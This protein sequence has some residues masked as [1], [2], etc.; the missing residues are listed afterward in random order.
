MSVI[1]VSHVALARARRDLEKAYLA[2]DWDHVRLCDRQLG[3][4]L[5]LAFADEHRN[6]RALVEELERVLGLYA[7]MVTA[8][9]VEAAGRLLPS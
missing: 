9:P 3:H 1:A 4:Q 7:R 5:N 2:G 6:N 8:L